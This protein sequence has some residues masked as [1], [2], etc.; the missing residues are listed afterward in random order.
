[1]RVKRARRGATAV[2]TA[3]FIPILVLFIVGMIQIGKITYLYYTLKKTLY[4]LAMT[5]A[6][7]QGV[8]FCGDSTGVIAS[9]INLALTGTT[10]GSGDALIPNLTPDL[11]NVQTECYDPNAQTVGACTTN[12][13]DPVAGGPPPDY[14][15]VS[16]SGGYLVQ[17]HIPY[18]T[19]D[20]IPLVPVIRVPFGGT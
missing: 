8:D 17:P 20:P 10:D 1:M 5:L 13:C 6:S 19:L 15:V 16:I 18:L 4:S 3:M 7:S 9:T 11:I 14:V 12:T 2:E